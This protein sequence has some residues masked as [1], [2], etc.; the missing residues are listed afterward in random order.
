MPGGTQYIQRTEGLRGASKSDQL[1]V[2]WIKPHGGVTS[3][4][5]ARW[6]KAMAGIN[7]DMFKAH[8]VRGASVSAAKN[9]GVTTREILDTAD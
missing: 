3:S 8:S 2:S 5:I 6:L 9:L 1:F 7:T 4:S